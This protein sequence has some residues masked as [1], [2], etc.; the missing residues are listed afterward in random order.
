MFISGKVRDMEN[1]KAIDELKSIGETSVHNIVY[2]IY[3]VDDLVDFHFSGDQKNA[4]DFLDFDENQKSQYNTI[5]RK[6]GDGKQ[7]D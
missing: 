1:D 3:K 5:K 4:L 6:Q 2:D 7:F